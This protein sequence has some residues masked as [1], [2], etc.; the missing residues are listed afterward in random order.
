MICRHTVATPLRG[1]QSSR[2]VST[3]LRCRLGQQHLP[4]VS[5]RR[6]KQ[7]TINASGGNTDPSTEQKPHPGSASARHLLSVSAL[8]FF[9]VSQSTVP[10]T[11][12]YCTPSPSERLNTH[13]FPPERVSLLQFVAILA[14]DRVINPIV[15]PLIPPVASLTSAPTP[16]SVTQPGSAARATAE[17]PDVEPSDILRAPVKRSKSLLR[18]LWGTA[19]LPV[20]L[21]VSWTLK[22]GD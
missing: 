1:A 10:W 9:S 3:P 19:T 18:T 17:R 8:A 15:P 2:L 7:P 5:P 12:H 4:C 14:K 22:V 11:N 6:V 13:C 20:K 21:V 16:S